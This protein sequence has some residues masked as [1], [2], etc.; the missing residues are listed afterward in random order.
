MRYIYIHIFKHYIYIYKYIHT[1]LFLFFVETAMWWTFSQQHILLE[2]DLAGNITVSKIMKPWDRI[3][4][5]GTMGAFLKKNTSLAHSL[6]S[7]QDTL[8]ALWKSGELQD[9]EPAELGGYKGWNVGHLGSGYACIYVYIYIYINIVSIY[10][11]IYTYLKKK[12]WDLK[13][14]HIVTS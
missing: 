11:T 12:H 9:L 5:P 1:K 14:S 8:V 4:L 6:L 3:F 2:D 13:P 7:R 10:I